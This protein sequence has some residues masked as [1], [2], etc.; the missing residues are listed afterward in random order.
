MCKWLQS[1]LEIQCRRPEQ[2]DPRARI[3][4]R[5]RS[6]RIDSEESIQTV[7]TTNRVVIPARQ[8]GNRSLGSMKGLQ[9]RAQGPPHLVSGQDHRRLSEQL[10]ESQMAIGN[11]EQASWR[12]LLEGVSQLG[13]DFAAEILFYILFTKKTSLFWFLWPSKIFISWHHPFKS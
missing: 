4:K 10:F 5:L 3:C 13:S 9:I 1:N 8:A 7:G 6:K 11:P 2:T 12:E